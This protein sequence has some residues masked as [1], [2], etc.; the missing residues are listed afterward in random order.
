MYICFSNKKD[1]KE[2]VCIYKRLGV[3]EIQ[4]DFISHKI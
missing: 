3:N 1:N 2:S 4:S